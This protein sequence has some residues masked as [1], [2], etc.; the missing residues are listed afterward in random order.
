M[1]QAPG[2]PQAAQPARGEGRGAKGGGRGAR[3]GAQAARGRDVIGEVIDHGNVESYNQGGK[4]ST[5]MNL[6][7]KDHELGSGREVNFERISQTFS[8]RSYS[9]FEEL[10]VGNVEVKNI[11]ELIDFMQE[12]QIWIVATVVNLELEREWSYVGCKKYSKKVDEVG[13][14]F[15]CKKC[16][17][18]DHSA[19][20]RL[21]VQVIDGTGSISLLLWDHEPTKLIGKSV[22]T[23]KEGVVET[24]GAAYECSHL[25]E[26]E[27]ILDGKFMFKLMVKPS[28]IEEKKCLF[29]E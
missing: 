24:S 14:K 6:E 20:K 10:A 28:N 21:Q 15:Y 27:A 1:V 9:I 7:L 29:Q 3:G 17:R 23:L 2:V 5:F 19:L 22:D 18:V 4:T 26:I 11:G 13:N 12:G 8:Q 16:E 25:L